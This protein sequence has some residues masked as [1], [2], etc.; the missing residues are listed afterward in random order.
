MKEKSLASLNGLGTLAG[1]LL[2]ALAGGALFVLGVA[3]KASTGSPNLLLMLAGVLVVAAAVF[4]LAGLYTIQ[5]NQAAVLS[6]FGK[7]VGTVKD[8][9]LR[10]N[11][12]FYAKRRV[13]QRVRNFESGKLKVNELDGS[14]IE[15]AAVIVWQVVD[16]SEAVY[17]V[18]DYES[19]VHI[20]SESALRAMA[21]SYPYDQHEDGQLALRS[22]ANEISQHLKNEL[23]ERLADAGVQVIDAR[24]SHLAYAAEIAQAM[25]QRQQANAVIAARTRI[26]AGAVGMVEMALAE[27]QKNGVVELDEERKAHMV[28]NLLTVLCSDRGTQPIVNAGSLY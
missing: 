10:W 15:I 1:S 2:A 11:N 3:A 14:P 4:I 25:L 26:V 16:A 7:Y 23:A 22:H 18:D 17:N 9:G 13:S 24:I 8:N 12:P 19:F 21:T 27:L 28:S 5:P 6:L 20:Q